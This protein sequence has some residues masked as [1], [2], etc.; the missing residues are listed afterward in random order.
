M[1]LFASVETQRKRPL[2]LTLFCFFFLIVTGY[3]L[4]TSYRELTRPGAYEAMQQIAV[5][6][7]LQVALFYL[8]L[9]ILITS[10]FF[11]LHAHNWA[12]WLFVSGALVHL[13]YY[14]LCVLSDW[15]FS[16]LLCGIYA[17]ILFFPKS[18]RYFKQE[19]SPP[20]A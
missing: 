7:F 3:H 10:S 15:A 2:Y 14:N 1:N 18:N 11:M 17:L 19:P 13:F 8:N 16:A 5:P 6:Y 9:I 20:S 12:R 4:I